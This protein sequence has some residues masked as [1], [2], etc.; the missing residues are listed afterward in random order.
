VDPINSVQFSNHSGMWWS[1]IRHLSYSIRMYF[2]MFKFMNY[3]FVTHK[4]DFW[5]CLFWVTADSR[6]CQCRPLFFRVTGCLF[7]DHIDE[8]EFFISQWK[9]HR[10]GG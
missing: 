4:Y 6:M 8:Q 5:S 1:A 7:N 9:L 10:K 2:Y 3:D